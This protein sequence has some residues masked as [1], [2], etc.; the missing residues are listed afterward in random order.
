MNKLF[1][2]FFEPFPLEEDRNAQ[3][4]STTIISSLVVVILAL[5][6]PFGLDQVTYQMAKQL[7]IYFGYGAVTFLLILMSDRLIKPAFPNFFDEQK[8]TVGKNILWTVFII[9]FIGVGNLFYSNALGFTGVSGTSML[10]F[11]IYTLIIA[12]FPVTIATLLQRISLLRK[13]LKQAEEIN[14]KLLQPVKEVAPESFLLFTS[15][16]EKETLKLSPEQFLYAESA[17]NY[18][19]IV[20]IENSIVKRELIRSTLKRIETINTCK[21]IVR[22]HRTYLVNLR[23]VKAVTGNSQ[24]YRM[25]FDDLEETVPVAKRASANVKKLLSE[26]HSQ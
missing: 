3:L 17:D 16:N 12:L 26:I 19:D 21:F 18:T 2:L 22:T 14:A 11:Q 9:V 5:F 1:K 6:K 10:T 7:P 13:N 8:W 24:G 20:Y 23:K 25:I 15:E 4:I